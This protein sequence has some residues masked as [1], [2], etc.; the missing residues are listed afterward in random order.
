M[1]LPIGWTAFEPLETSELHRW[2]ML[3]LSA[4][5]SL[6]GEVPMEP[7][8]FERLALEI[9][10]TQGTER[11]LRQ[12]AEELGFTYLDDVPDRARLWVL[13]RAHAL[14]QENN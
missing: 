3:S 1:G 5:S 11:Y 12:A 8:V 4:L 6:S 13:N 2:R 14:K 10:D 9:V 7:D